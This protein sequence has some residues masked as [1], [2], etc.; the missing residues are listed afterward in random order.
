[1]V[2]ALCKYMAISE[3]PNLNSKKNYEKIVL[4]IDYIYS[5]DKDNLYDILGITQFS[6]I[7]MFYVVLEGSYQVDIGPSV[8]FECDWSKIPENWFA[9]MSCT[10]EENFELFPEKLSL[11]DGWFEKYIDEDPDVLELVKAEINDI[12]SKHLVA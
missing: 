1:M 10:Y 4:P 9:R 7:L 5:F 11:V 3:I 12:R 2:K 8:L 6:G